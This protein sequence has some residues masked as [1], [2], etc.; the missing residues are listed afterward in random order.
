MAL[1]CF[2]PLTFVVSFVLLAL[3]P[4]LAYPIDPEA[5]RSPYPYTPFLAFPIPELL[6]SISIWSLV[7]HL[8]DPFFSIALLIANTFPDAASVIALLL[9]TTL[10]VFVSII[11]RQIAVL[12]LLIPHHMLYPYP[13]WQDPAFRQVWWL[14]L[15]WAAMESVVAI[16][17]GYDGIALYR[18]VLVSKPTP[19]YLDRSTSRSKTYGAT[20]N[21]HRIG[22]EC[23]GD[24]PQSIFVRSPC[25]G[26]PEI[27]SHLT[28]FG[29]EQVSLLPRGHLNGRINVP[30]EHELEVQLDR[31]LDQ[32]I[33]LK[34]REELEEVYGMPFIVCTF[35][36]HRCGFINL[37][38]SGSEFRC[39]SLACNA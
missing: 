36:H 35:Y 6:T 5:S 26:S 29:R 1:Y 38:E 37:W 27:S 32:L 17:Q 24:S 7:H 20:E 39:L 34:N 28:E 10:H 22:E 21:G 8:R 13:T 3:L 33:A 31:D 9:S 19:S 12:L 30:S 11:F 15:G 4:S 16:K 2:V 25:G 23:S 14:G 18:G